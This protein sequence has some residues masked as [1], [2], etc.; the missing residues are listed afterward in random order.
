MIL[1]CS[2]TR[3]LIPFCNRPLLFR[4]EDPCPR[5]EIEIITVEGVFLGRQ[6]FVHTCRVRSRFVITSTGL[7]LSVTATLARFSNMLYLL[8]QKRWYHCQ[9]LQDYHL[10]TIQLESSICF[11]FLPY[12]IDEIQVIYLRSILCIALQQILIH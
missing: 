1:P 2:T 9:W 11:L 3:G 5:R 12:S 4:S 6:F 8:I 7:L 10:C